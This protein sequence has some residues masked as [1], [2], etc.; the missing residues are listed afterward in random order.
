MYLVEVLASKVRS[1]DGLVY[2][3]V[4]VYREP[5]MLTCRMLRVVMG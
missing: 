5:H 2:I 3:S 4:C 1:I